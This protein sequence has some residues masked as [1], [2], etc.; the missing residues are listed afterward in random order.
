[1][2]GAY[3]ISCT[4]SINVMS[5][6]MDDFKVQCLYHCLVHPNNINANV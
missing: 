2:K 1:M 3:A 6:S 5:V 4:D